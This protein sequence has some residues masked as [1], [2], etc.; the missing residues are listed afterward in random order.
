[1]RLPYYQYKKEDETK[2]DYSDIIK[3]ISRC[4]SDKAMMRA[5]VVNKAYCEPLKKAE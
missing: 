4:F 1:M 5:K 3:N 2:D